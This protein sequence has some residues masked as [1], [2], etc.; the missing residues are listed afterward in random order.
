MHQVAVILTDPKRKI[1]WVN[2]YFEEMT[3]YRKQEVLGK[4]PGRLLQGPETDPDSVA[5][6]K[7]ALAAEKPFEDALINYRKNGEAYV[8]RLAIHPIFDHRQQL[9]NFMAFESDGGTDIDNYKAHHVELPLR[10]KTSSLRGLQEIR[11]FQKVEELLDR[12]RLFLDSDLTLK[13][14]ASRLETNVKYL[15]QVINLHGGS[16]FLGFINNYRIEEFRQRLLAGDSRHTTLYGIAQRC[17]FK[18]KSTFFKVF[19]DKKG[20]TP[21]AF[22]SLIM[23]EENGREQNF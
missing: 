10:Y 19:R 8:C 22:H 4:S 20:M 21:K 5:R 3:G 13:V 16:N 6:I 15:S 18:N 12:E 7:K 17:G 9:V 14:M 2:D 11:L 1:L 23:N